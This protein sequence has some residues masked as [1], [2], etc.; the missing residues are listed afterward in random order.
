[1]LSSAWI[2]FFYKQS[3]LDLSENIM[4]NHIALT[5]RARTV[6]DSEPFPE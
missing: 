5:I 3:F 2:S 4:T 6:G 1:M